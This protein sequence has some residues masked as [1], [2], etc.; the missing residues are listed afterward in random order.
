MGSSPAKTDEAPADELIERTLSPFD[1]DP[2]H[3]IPALQAMQIALGYLPAISLDAVAKH[4][5][6]P[7]S[8]VY[9]IA[10]FY[11]QFHLTR[12]GDHRIKICW[13][14]ACH[15]R[16]SGMIMSVVHK[17]LGI[18]PG[19]T[20]PDY[21]FTME[22]VACLGSCALAP[23]VVVDDQV[24]GQMTPESMESLLDSCE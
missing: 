22:R 16:G 5:R 11:A 2:S 3:L 14:T 4:F 21:K 6:V 12:Q 10:T 20:T 17:K 15:V 9:G 13:G 23:V 18:L 24:H 1:E 19:E 8:R 7:A